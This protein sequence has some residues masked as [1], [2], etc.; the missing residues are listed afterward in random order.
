MLDYMAGNL[1]NIVAG[2]LVL[3]SVGLAI[4]K[5]AR[6][7]KNHVSSCGGCSGCAGCP[8]SETCSLNPFS[9]KE[10]QRQVPERNPDH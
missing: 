2:T 7:K 4:G 5:I 6:N 9:Q 1:A 8:K 3:V 10:P